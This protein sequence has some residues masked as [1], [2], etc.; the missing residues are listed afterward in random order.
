[1]LVEF[2]LEL[3]YSPCG[4]LRMEVKDEKQVYYI[5]FHR[6]CQVR[7]VQRLKLGKDDSDKA[8]SNFFQMVCLCM[9]LFY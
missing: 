2:Y 6:V 5:I 3:I 4:N 9:M 1:M 7:F 8:I